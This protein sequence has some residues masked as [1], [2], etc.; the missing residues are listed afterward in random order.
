MFLPNIG[1]LLLFIVQT[2]FFWPSSPKNMPVGGN[3]SQIIAVS[4]FIT[5]GSDGRSRRCFSFGGFLHVPADS[6]PGSWAL[7]RS[8]PGTNTCAVR[9]ESKLL[10]K[11]PAASVTLFYMLSVARPALCRSGYSRLFTCNRLLFTAPYTFF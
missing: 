8:A 3:M 11:M 4:A 2:V 1:K 9:P 6:Y 10:P 5:A 7:D